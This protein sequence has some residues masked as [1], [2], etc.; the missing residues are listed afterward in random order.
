MESNPHIGTVS[1][2]NRYASLEWSII[3]C[4][5]YGYS[6]RRGN[7]FKPLSCKFLI[8]ISLYLLRCNVLLGNLSMTDQFIA[9]VI[10]VNVYNFNTWDYMVIKVYRRFPDNRTPIG[11]NLFISF[12][13]SRL[14]HFHA[15]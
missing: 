5:S 10:K 15:R 4:K 9:G 3:R 11:R 8:P 2:I 7:S 6:I 13:W 14:F 12:P 1:N